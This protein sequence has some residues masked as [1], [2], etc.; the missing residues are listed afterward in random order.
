MGV[1]HRLHNA[2]KQLANPD[3]RKG[4]RLHF[5]ST[6]FH[7]LGEVEVV[8][9]LWMVPLL[10]AMAWFRGWEGT[11][12]YIDQVQYGEPIFVAAIMIV[13]ASKP[14]LRLAESLLSRV[15]GLGRGTPM[16]WWLT[17][18]SVG[19]LLGSLI[20]EPAAMTI[21][22]LLLGE[23]FYRL[24]PDFTL[25]YATLGLLFVNISVG[26]ILTHFAAPPVVMVA[27]RWNWDLAFMAGNFGWKAVVGILLS[28]LVYLAV[29][30]RQL[31]ALRDPETGVE[32]KEKRI[33]PGVTLIH[34]GFIVWLVLTAHHT[35]LVVFAV[36]FY[37]AF[38]VATEVFQDRLALR[39][40]LLVGFF[41]AGLVTHGG[42]QKWWIVPVLSGLGE[43]PLMLGATG[44]DR[45]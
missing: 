9:G 36:L 44:P 21:C 25:R 33:P 6:L 45:L 20:T 8:F 16:A 7:F 35:A 24:Q 19:P 1:S 37:I 32:E 14:I 17:L 5:F 18:L 4:V 31:R 38:T 27:S 42:C 34:L 22:A 23:R 13:A 41:L 26:G 3:S 10:I 39:G 28:N 15:A 40:P 2:R 30:S 29:F 43:W 12:N 11:M